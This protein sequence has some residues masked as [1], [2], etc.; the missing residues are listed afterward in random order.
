M[1]I[2]EASSKIQKEKVQEHMEICGESGEG[3]E[4]PCPFSIT[5]AYAYLHLDVPKLYP[6]V[7]NW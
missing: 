1:V 6:F 2:N 7:V 4:A 5:L 3:T